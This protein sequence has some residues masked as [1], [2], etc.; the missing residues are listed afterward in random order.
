MF[1]LFFN[2]QLRVLTYF[3]LCVWVWDSRTPHW[4]H[5]IL[6]ELFTRRWTLWFNRGNHYFQWAVF[7]WIF[8]CLL[9]QPKSLK[10][11]LHLSHENGVSPEWTRLCFLR[12]PF[13]LNF[14]SHLSHAC[15]L[16]LEWISLWVFRLLDEVNILSHFSHANGFTLER[17]SLW[18]FRLQDRVNVLSHLSHANVFFLTINEFVGFQIIRFI[19]VF[20]HLSHAKNFHLSEHVYA[21]WYS[22]F[23]W[24]SY[25][26]YHMQMVFL[27]NEYV[28][29]L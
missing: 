5:I 15:G 12:T 4:Y 13:R 18:D 14:L 16:S 19:N 6:I 22:P 25:Y 20:S 23:L 24:T 3:F 21:F 28:Y 10:H 2:F 9:F 11:L 8:L 26:I 1:N 7:W 17:I 27:E 29:A